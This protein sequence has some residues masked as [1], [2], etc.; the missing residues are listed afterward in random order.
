MPI[1]TKVLIKSYWHSSLLNSAH[2]KENNDARYLHVE[3]E[4]CKFEGIMYD[5]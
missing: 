1:S 5:V 2:V 3:N 4:I